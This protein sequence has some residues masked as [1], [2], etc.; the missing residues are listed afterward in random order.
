MRRRDENEK[1]TGMIR[2]IFL[3]SIMVMTAGCAAVGPGYVKPEP[4]VPAKWHSPLTHGLNAGPTVAKDLALWWQTLE[5]PVLCNLVGRAIDGNPDVKIAR[6]RIREARAERNLAAADYHPRADASG[7]F[8]QSRSSRQ[9]GGGNISHVYSAGIDASWEFD[10]FGGIDRALEAA[11]GDLQATEENLRDVMVSLVAEVGIGYVEARAYQT[12]IALAHENLKAQ[13]ETHRLIEFRLAAGLTTELAVDQARYNLEST[14]SQIPTLRMGLESSLNRLA[15]LLGDA[16]GQVHDALRDPRPVPVTP[17]RVAVGV[18]AD[19]LRQRPDIRRAERE[20]AA[21][22]ARVGVAVSELY[23]KLTLNGSIGFGALTFA[24]LFLL[25][26]RTLSIGPQ[27]RL[28]LFDAGAIRNNIEIQSAR[29]EQALV[30]YEA[31]ILAAL[32]EVENALDT[33]AET[34]NRRGALAAAADAAQKAADLSKTQYHAGLVDFSNVL[35]AERSLLS[36]QDQLA[37]SDGAVTLSL[38][39]LYKALGGGWEPTDE[40]NHAEEGG[41]G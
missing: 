29:Q 37:Q 14:R 12:R 30:T 35:D 31:S 17:L 2:V 9:T 13:E 5:D 32:E 26:S 8:T 22:T 10:L 19:V 15:V 39:G 1:A 18:P 6:L 23:P 33:F 36:F 16:P 25:D 3:V 11:E 20:L 7:A 21:Q 41:S 34:Q 38:I 40:K 27:V 28:P 24:D 4:P